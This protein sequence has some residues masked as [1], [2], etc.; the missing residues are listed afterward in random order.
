MKVIKI[1]L[2]G[3]PCAGKTTMLKKLTNYLNEKGI[4]NVVIPEAATEL[5]VNGIVFNGI[6]ESVK[7][8]QDMVLKKQIFNE[9]LAKDYITRVYFPVSKAVMICDRGLIDGKAYL[10]NEDDFDE[11]LKNNNISY[12]NALDSYD[13]VINLITI[14][15]CN[16]ELYN[17]D[18][19]ARFETPEEAIK[20]DR[21]TSNA[22]ALHRNLK[23]VNTSISIDE[24]AKLIFD[25][26]DELFSV[27]K[28]NIESYLVDLDNQAVYDYDFS[29]LTCQDYYLDIDNNGYDYV[30]K[31]RIKN[32]D[33][34][35]LFTV[36]KKDHE[37]V[38]IIEDKVISKKNFDD[39]LA[40]YNQI[41]KLNYDELCFVHNRQL[42]TFKLNGN[43][44]ILEVEK[45]KL[46]ESFEM[47][48][49]VKYNYQ[50]SNLAAEDYLTES[51]RFVKK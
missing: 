33:I 34:S 21:K 37:N 44:V 14:A 8:F 24:E 4:N 49:C 12:I 42:Y 20:T 9:N 38:M 43:N 30:V 51:K 2:T 19:E 28:R 32:D 50:I 6:D 31:K 11:I 39:L 27:Q 46:N 26:L 36:S 29:T 40:K 18:N 17:F 47:P 16:K 48:T 45:N 13:L 22:W 10:N 25:Y 1:A 3:G 41:K 15:D 23:I 5:I 35:Y 7:N